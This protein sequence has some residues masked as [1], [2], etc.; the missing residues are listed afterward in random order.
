M[1]RFPI[2][3]I[4]LRLLFVVLG[5][6]T[7]TVGGNCQEQVIFPFA[8]A[9]Q[10]SGFFA[11][12]VRD[13]KSNLYVPSAAG[14][15]YEI[16]PP[17][18]A[19]GQWQINSSSAV[20]PST[21]SAN[22]LTIDHSSNVY[23]TA[24]GG[25][26][27]VDY[28]YE[29]PAPCCGTT[30]VLYQFPA[31]T[32][33]PTSLAI[34]ASGNLYGAVSSTTSYIFELKKPSTKQGTWTE[35]IL[36]TF[37][38]TTDGCGP[39]GVII[40]K[41]ENLYGITTGCGANGT[42]TIF[43]L[44]PPTSSA[45]SWTEE[46]LYAFPVGGIVKSGMKKA[47]AP[48]KGNNAVYENTL[49]LDAS[50]NLYGAS[51]IGGTSGNGY[52]YELAAPVSGGAWAFSTLYSFAGAPDGAVPS[53]GVV[54]GANGYLYGTTYYGGTVTQWTGA[55]Y[56]F[57][58]L[59]EL[60]PPSTSGG[61]W[62]EKI[63]HNFAGGFDGFLPASTP[64]LGSGGVLFGLTTGGGDNTSGGFSGNRACCGAVYEYVP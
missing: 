30:N 18:K 55:L 44:V 34:D 4:H 38:G 24:T 5:V 58:I 50:G 32:L 2:S 40:D 63:I 9:N 41:H 14:N 15:V 47:L 45:G 11:G 21:Q 29:V 51:A 17:V 28:V 56:G 27:I 8:A 12:P 19:G 16:S 37:L 61:K 31:F 60:I 10:I 36:Y 33:A 26:T 62:T 54:V 1:K 3:A 64:I 57:G 59:Y 6:A 13:S 22:G 35:S 25:S 20:L 53:G 46:T 39:T 7:L 48:P 43:E 49:S 52:V 23:G 42:G